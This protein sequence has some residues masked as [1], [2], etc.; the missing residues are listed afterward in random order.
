[1]KALFLADLYQLWINF[2]FYGLFVVVALGIT[3]FSSGDGDLGTFFPMYAVIMCSMMGMSLVQL[4][5]GSRWNICAQTLPCTR[6]D[7]VTGK[8]IVTMASF[9]VTWIPF[10]LLYTVLAALGRMTWQMMG[11]Q[12][13]MLLVVGLLAP[14]FSLPPLFRWG[15]AKG[16][17]IYIFIVILIAAG[18]G[19]TV[20][21]LA[22]LL[23]SIK[24]PALPLPLLAALAVVVLIALFI[25]SWALSVRWYEKREL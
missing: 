17:V 6:R 4:D 21:G 23:D 7:Q 25:G 18:M 1:M 13:A 10:V 12:T 19:S 9:A 5:E 16:R 8:Y 20:I 14:A 15:S 22:S 3:A 2:K 11:V 24:L